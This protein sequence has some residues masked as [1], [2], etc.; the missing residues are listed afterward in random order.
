MIALFVNYV[1]CSF[2]AKLR[3]FTRIMKHYQI[4]YITL[5]MSISHVLLAQSKGQFEFEETE[6]DFGTVKEENGSAIHE[7][8]FKNV[9]DAPIVI[10]RVK[11]SCGCTTP[12]WSSE[13]VLPGQKGYIKAQYNTRNRPGTF[14]KTLTVYSNADQATQNLY[15][16]GN[17]IPKT[18]SIED[19]LKVKDGGLRFQSKNLNLSKITTKEPV[20]KTFEVYND[21][22]AAITMLDKFEGSKFIRLSFDTAVILPKKSANLVVWY[23]PNHE[24]NLGMNTHSVSF[25]TSD[26]P[27]PKIVSIVVRIDEYFAPLSEKE[28]AVAPRLL[29]EERVQDLGTINSGDKVTAQFTL[30]NGGV[31]KLNIRKVDTNCSCMTAKLDSENIKGGDA[32]TLTITFDSKGR[33]GRQTKSISVY[34]NDPNDPTQLISIKVSVQP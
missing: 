10:S 3:A 8:T 21:S 17:V 34:S 5:L 31:N 6:H 4:I 26:S 11:A 30:R 13:P 23:D 12:G 14:R 33:R 22:E 29:I 1:L 15:I 27:D 25:Y 32:T 24:D 20:T 18:L 16:K 19:K 2:A 7:F 9:G 28:K